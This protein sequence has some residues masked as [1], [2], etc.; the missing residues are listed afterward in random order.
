MLRVSI[1][2]SCVSR[3]AFTSEY[4]DVVALGEYFARSSVASAGSSAPFDVTGSLE[5]IQSPFQRRIVEYDVTKAFLSY[6]AEADF[7]ILL[8]DFIDERF[9]LVRDGESVATRSDEFLRS[10]PDESKLTRIPSGSDEHFDLWVKGW[11]AI[12]S[13]IDAGPGRECIRIS[14]TYWATTSIDGKGFA[15]SPARIA[16]ANA[17]LDR[18]YAR[19]EQDLGEY[20]FLRYRAEDLRGD[21]GHQW[22]RSPF[23]YVP[24]FYQRLVSHLVGAVSGEDSSI[25]DGTG[26]LAGRPVDEKVAAAIGTAATR[27][28]TTPGAAVTMPTEGVL[29]VDFAEVD[30][31]LLTHQVTIRLPRTLR[32]SS[33]VHLRF[34]LEGW[35]D[36]VYVAVGSRQPEVGFQHIKARHVLQGEW[37]EFPV[38]WDDLMFKIQN[39]WEP[40]RARDVSA[41]ELYIRAT[42]ESS[43]GRV[44]LDE[45]FAWSE[46]PEGQ[47][48]IGDLDPQQP[49]FGA[50]VEHLMRDFTNLVSEVDTRRY[51]ETGDF[52]I[53]GAVSLVW[54]SNHAVPP[55]IGE[56]PTYRYLWH[57]LGA[58]AQMAIHVRRADPRG[59]ISPFVRLITNWIERSYFHPDADMKYA[60]YDHGTAER[61]MSIL[62]VR[63]LL[64][65]TKPDRRLLAL[66]DDVIIQHAL[67]LEHEAFYAYHQNSRYHNHAW[68]QDIA[69]LAAGA[70]TKSAASARWRE[71]GAFRLRNQIETL[72]GRDG[73]YAVLAENSQGYHGGTQMMVEFASEILRDATGDA[74]LD[75]YAEGMEKWTDRFRF[76]NGRPPANGDSY[77]TP[78]PVDPVSAKSFRGAA[79]SSVDV[80]SDMGYAVIDGVDADAPFFFTMLATSKTATHKHQD[81]LAVILHFGGVEWLI[82]PS[83]YSHQYHEPIPAYLRSALA[84]N[85][86]V[87]DDLPYSIEPGRA[88][89]DGSSSDHDFEFWGEH[90]A[91]PE[92]AV[93]RRV[94][95]RTDRLDLSFED[96]VVA[97]GAVN[98]RLVL[99]LGDGVV[100]QCDGSQAIL[101]HPAS[102]HRLLVQLEGA[103]RVLEGMD[104][105]GAVLSVTGTAFQEWLPTTTLELPVVLEG[106]SVVR[107]SVRS[108]SD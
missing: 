23:H 5:D 72:V 42:S 98:G 29:A 78:N 61:L 8:L 75:L 37:L 95:G 73:N 10:N 100:A 47:T 11:E 104:D 108:Y 58:A 28:I 92:V 77:R 96:S 90:T 81:N 27:V 79:A 45:A 99:H 55:G 12:L 89:L 51:L 86:L 4:A 97:S 82:D 67:L 84:H 34:K 7:D 35:R 20:Q 105:S 74:S 50:L 103:P 53:R 43:V 41:V 44:Y 102:A 32:D 33:G 80:L 64:G 76:P 71:R 107:W 39:G 2:G 26:V 25:A 56:L 65:E 38:A 93:R 1:L 57:S 18:L 88:W 106:D 70:L 13:A 62:I 52:P 24:S 60:W 30:R 59:D 54:P 91:Y 40:P 85:V 3:D 22:G 15:Q 6:I 19:A 31:E 9:D 46:T 68:F 63:G 16:K 36:L 69:L 66:L 14:K 48:G 17:F 49:T 94:K 21:P 87:V 83:F 101:S